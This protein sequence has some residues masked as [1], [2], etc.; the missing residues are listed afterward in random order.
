MHRHP[1]RLDEGLGAGARHHL[2]ALGRHLVGVRGDHRGRLHQLVDHVGRLLRAGG[3]GAADV[4]D[5]QVGLEEPADHRLLLGRHPGVAGKIGG[6]PVAEP[7]HV[8]AGRADIGG[9]PRLLHVGGEIAFQEG[10]VDAVGVHRRHA[11]DLHPVQLAR[12]AEADQ[13]HLVLVAAGGRDL[14][15]EPAVHLAADEELGLL[16]DH[17]VDRVADRHHRHRDVRRTAG[18][19]VGPGAVPVAQVVAVDM[20]QQHAVDAPQPLVVGAAY[21]APGVIEQPRAVRVLEDQRPVEAAELAGVA[22]Q[23]RDLHVLGRGRRRG[24]GQG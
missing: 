18:P 3:E 12:G 5:H 1:G 7:D 22:A 10:R 2:A 9:E 4:H 23:W 14:L 20:A 24:Q 6:E 19:G 16:L 15:V 8:A 17:D 13:Q 21:R 11:V